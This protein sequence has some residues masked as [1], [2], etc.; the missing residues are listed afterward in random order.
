VTTRLEEVRSGPR[1]LNEI[2]SGRPALGAVLGAVTV[3]VSAILVRLADVSPEVAAIFRCV[4]ALPPLGA[5]ALIE[6]RRFGGRPVRAR[7]LAWI[8]GAFLG[9][10]LIFWHHAI[11]SV[12][13]GLATVLGNL[14]V[15]VVGLLAHFLLGERLR[16]E[17]IAA[18]VLAFSGVTLI[19]GAF[20][21]GAYG[22]DP[23]RGV[24]FGVLTSLAYAGF[25]LVMRRGA[26]DLRRVAGPLFDATLASA[27]VAT[28]VAAF[29][30]PLDLLPQWPAHGWLVVLALSCQ[31]VGWLLIS[32]SLPRLP[33]AVTSVLLLVQPVVSVGLGIVVL[34]ESPSAL[35][36]SGVGLVLGGVVLATRGRATRPSF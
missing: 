10:D 22:D 18:I 32:T 35:Q 13:A 6:N 12:G 14:Q 25:L 3:G 26:A 7:A 1:S 20:E 4:Y 11:D 5:L 30:G 36:L 28:A 31:V 8:A 16:R 29:T 34:S 24:L 21:H 23:A 2:V 15:V 27:L 17:I 33:A 9:I 19:S